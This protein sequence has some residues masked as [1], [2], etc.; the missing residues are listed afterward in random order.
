MNSDEHLLPDRQVDL[1]SDGE[2]TMIFLDLLQP[3]APRKNQ[4]SALTDLAGFT[5]SDLACVSGV[6]DATL[7]NWKT[8]NTSEPLP[9]VLDDIRVV[10]EYVA[11]NDIMKIA[12]IGP[13]FISPNRYLD[14]KPPLEVMNARGGFESVLSAIQEE[15]IDRIAIARIRNGQTTGSTSIEEFAAEFGLE[16]DPNEQDSES[17]DP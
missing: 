15:Q 16:V 14:R 5:I 2:D 8:D 12:E 10:T 3:E 11:R 17:T 4:V 1:N 7:S 6:D 13:W 9:D